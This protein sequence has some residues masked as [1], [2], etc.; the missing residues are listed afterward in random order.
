[1][2][3]QA[4]MPERPE[5]QTDVKGNVNRGLPRELQRYGLFS[6]CVH[7]IGQNMIDIH[8]INFL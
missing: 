6:Q 4:W 2:A 1:M 3:I 7:S 8:Q 5:L